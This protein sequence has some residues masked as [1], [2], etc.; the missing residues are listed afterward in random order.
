MRLL[1]T[2]R[3]A[4]PY[5]ALALG[6]TIRRRLV[7][8]GCLASLM[9]SLARANQAPAVAGATAGTFAAGN[10]Y[11][12]RTDLVSAYG[13]VCDGTSHPISVATAAARYPGLTLPGS[14]NIE[15]DWAAIQYFLNTGF[16]YGT[17]PAGSIPVLG[18]RQIVLDGSK[19]ALG[20]CGPDNSNLIYTGA[21]AGTPPVDFVNYQGANQVTVNS[22]PPMS[23]PCPLRNVTLD[24]R[25]GQGG[26][27]YTTPTINGSNSTGVA[28]TNFSTGTVPWTASNCFN[29]RFENFSWQG[30]DQQPIMGSNFYCWHH[31]GGYVVGNNKGGGF[32]T[33]SSTTTSGERMTFAG[34]TFSNNNVNIQMDITNGVGADLYISRCSID[35]P[36]VAHAVT[37]D[38]GGANANSELF[39]DAGVHIETSTART[40]NG[41]RFLVGATRLTIAD[42]E[43]LENGQGPLG[44]VA[45]TDTSGGSGMIRLRNLSVY[46]YNIPLCIQTDGA[47]HDFDASGCSYRYPNSTMIAYRS[48]NGDRAQPSYP[49]SV[50]RTGNTP[51]DLTVQN[52]TIF[53]SPPSGGTWYFTIDDTVTNHEI[54]TYFSVVILGAGN[55]GFSGANGTK[56]NGTVNGGSFS[57]SGAGSVFRAIKT[58]Y[59]TYVTVAA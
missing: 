5:R 38:T 7:L 2:R 36:N 32:Q 56:I 3:H 34:V 23:N 42:C 18:G 51:M 33:T 30:F 1:R 49:P 4:P 11:R 39:I 25:M 45:F 37:T 17:W 27:G 46:G 35:Y 54:G 16:G 53:A 40:G 14:G 57:N 6:Q 52:K 26:G 13:A 55:V 28:H 59:Q 29:G 44:L 31:E 10:D 19:R 24:A 50:T 47:T 12:I 21:V 41:P 22:V 9:P 15:T 48:A 43:V 8:A 20:I 58:A